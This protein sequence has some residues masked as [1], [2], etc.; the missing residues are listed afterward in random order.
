[1]LNN[2][3]GIYMDKKDLPKALAYYN[4]SLVI[5]EENNDKKGVSTSLNNI[6]GIYRGLSLEQGDLSTA[7]LY[8]FKSLK[9]SEELNDRQGIASTLNNIGRIYYDKNNIVKA[10]EYGNKGLLL[11]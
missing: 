4:K 9:L 5:H 10:L 11:V 1:M 6:A 2:I 8:F 7:L 3:G